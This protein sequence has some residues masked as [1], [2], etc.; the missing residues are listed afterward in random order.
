LE[1]AVLPPKF[2]R[3]M[4]GGG[5]SAEGVVEKSRKSPKKVSNGGKPQGEERVR[6]KVWEQ[7]KKAP[8]QGYRMM[9]GPSVWKTEKKTP[10]TMIP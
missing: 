10:G 4:T 5:K 3:V 7:T 1:S 6:K 2:Q 9:K 8:N